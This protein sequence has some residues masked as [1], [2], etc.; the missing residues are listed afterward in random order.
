MEKESDF[1][2]L[3]KNLEQYPELR[4][5][6][7]N[8]INNVGG[9][10]EKIEEM[11]KSMIGL[12]LIC[13]N[14]DV[15]IPKV[16]LQLNFIVPLQ[17]KKSKEIY[18]INIRN[19]INMYKK[20]YE[21][22]S[23]IVNKIIDE[24]KQSL[25][26]L[27]NPLKSLHNNI[28]NYSNNFETSLNQLRIPLENGKKGLNDINYKK[29]SKDK[30]NRFI[31]DKNEV[32]KEI[33]N[34]LKEAND[35]YKDYGD[36][37]KA[38]SEDVNNLVER[39]YSLAMLA[40]ELSIFMRKLMKSFENSSNSFN[41]FNDKEKLNKV[42]EEIKEPIYKF[43]NKS[44]KFE[45]L[46]SLIRSIKI[47]RINEIIEI[48]NKIKGKI[49]KLEA[50]SKTI[51]EKIKK[52]RDK[53]GEPEESL[54]KINI[55]PAEVI[56]CEKTSNQIEE[57]G[58]EIAKTSDKGVKD[59]TGDINKIRTQL[60]LDLLFIMDITGSMEYYL[61]QVK[62]DILKMIS[63]VRKECSGV[64]I[65]LGFI[66]YRDFYDLDRGDKYINLE[67]TTDYEYIRKNIENVKVGGGGDTPED[68]CGGLELGIKKDWKGKTR[69]AVLATDSPCHG[70]KYHDLTGDYQDNYPDGDREGRNIEE[71]IEFFAKNEISLFC[72]KIDSSTDKMFKIFEEE[73]NK[74]KSKNSKKKFVLEEGLKLIDI[75][76]KNA[77]DMFQ[78]RDKLEIS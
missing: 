43:Y 24:T 68:L 11:N 37:S 75:V 29:Y 78:H 6:I 76:V 3:E 28:K 12:L 23:A 59:I 40:K 30:Q 26:K 55:P 34:F 44:K 47:K 36:L 50:N 64:D 38:T 62:H 17:M 35:F 20:L 14:P 56:N 61:A 18:V 72:L 69:F 53:Y 73:Y 74:N 27:Y 77:I 15:E 7:F 42:I 31:K 67:F 52:I 22:N 5:A 32:I 39:F 71:Y 41:D 60:R 45:N 66:G 21:K 9:S 63:T 70:K 58:K 48:S 25:E 19:D 49:N 57:Q 13:D 51:S 16:P 10:F 65:Y 2:F 4:S 33:D 46:L 8:P 54:S 1:D